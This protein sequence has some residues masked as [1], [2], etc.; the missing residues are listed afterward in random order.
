MVL[1]LFGLIALFLLYVVNLLKVEYTFFIL[2]FL[3]LISGLLVEEYGRNIAGISATGL[4]N[5]LTLGLFVINLP[6]FLKSEN[7][8]RHNLLVYSFILFLF[9]LIPIV[10][11]FDFHIFTRFISSFGAI[12]SIYYLGQL[13]FQ[14]ITNFE[15]KFICFLKYF[16]I[17]ATVAGLIHAITV[18]FSIEDAKINNF[19]FF[20]FEYP[21]SFSIFASSLFPIFFF[22]IFNKQVSKYYYIVIFILFPVAILY[23]GAKIGLI[24]YFATLVGTIIFTFRANMADYLYSYIVL[25]IGLLI[26]INTPVYEDLVEILSVPLDTYIFTTSDYSINSFHTRVKVWMYM[27]FNL[28]HEDNLLLGFG[29]RAWSLKYLALSGASSSQSDYFTVLFELGLVGLVGFI[30][31]RVLLICCFFKEGKKNIKSYYLA[32]GCLCSL[33]IGGLTENIEG[34]PSTSWL[35]PFFLSLSHYLMKHNRQPAMIGK[36]DPSELL[37]EKEGQ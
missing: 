2:F 33:F 30:L 35:I 25:A 16:F 7:K 3:H 23:S 18:G 10:Y 31:Y 12:I 13:S 5:F 24:V 8:F 14:K 17:F 9:Y 27:L 26:F 29:W 20:F 19:T 4:I 37:N 22:Y 21:H 34:Y 11:N 1:I 15:K 28:L 36:E 6:H 32:I